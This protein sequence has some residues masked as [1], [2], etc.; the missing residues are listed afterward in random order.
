MATNVFEVS[1]ESVF[2]VPNKSAQM[3]RLALRALDSGLTHFTAKRYELAITDFKKAIR[4]APTADSTVNAYDYMARAQLSQG[5]TRAAI[6]TYEKALRID[7][8]RDDLHS[9]LGN[10]YTTQGEKEKAVKE[11]ALAVTNNPRSAANRYSLGQGYLATGQNRE[12]LQQF[13]FVRQLDPTS[14]YGDFGMGQAYAKL[15]RY[16]E[17]VAAF[18]RAIDM[19]SDYWD[20][21]AEKGYALADSGASEDALAIAEK[22]LKP[23]PALSALV[24]QYTYEHSAPKMIASYITSLYTPFMSTL[25]P[26]T[27]VASLGGYLTSANASQTVAMEFQFSK[28]MDAA[29]VENV[30]NWSIARNTG[31]GLGDGYNWDMPLAST[32]V[33]LDPYPTSVMYNS[34]TLVATVM[35]TLRQNGTANGTLDPSH[36]KFSFSGK[37]ATGMSMDSSADEYM[38]VNGFA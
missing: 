4:L 22:L 38:G 34:E 9:Q 33:T 37:D 14:P 24:S 25:G 28:Q 31:T 6:E 16:D 5:D 21:Y 11:Y 23:S 15:E 32:E 20:A 1:A 13:Q 18:D 36:I 17:A 2:V 10:I 30:Y 27:A 19:K 7:P 12:A 35:F 8:T 29:S 26:K 3:E